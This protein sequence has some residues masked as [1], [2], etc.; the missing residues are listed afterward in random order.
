MGFSEDYFKQQLKYEKL[1]GP[2][3]IVLMQKGDFFEMF[4]Y[5][6]DIVDDNDK[7]LLPECFEQKLM[8]KVSSVCDSCT[9]LSVHL[10][11]NKLDHSFKNLIT[12]GFRL[13]S[14]E[15]YKDI[16][17]K[18][19]WVP[20]QII[21]S[22]SNKQIRILGEEPVTPG[23]YIK[24]DSSEKL[25]NNYI[26]NVYIEIIS[27]K[28]R[29]SNYN[30]NC[31]ISCLDVNTG[32][33]EISEI[34]N[35]NDDSNYAIK[36]IY[37][38]LISKRPQEV[39]IYVKGLKKVDVIEGYENYLN[40]S[41]KLENYPIK[42][43]KYDSDILKE[44]FEIS[45]Q[46]SSLKKIFNKKFETEN[47]HPKI[48]LI[49]N[50]IINDL[51]LHKIN[52]GRI[53]YIML[54]DHV[55]KQ[56]PKILYKIK[57][58][59]IGWLDN[60]NLILTHNAV[61]Q[62]NLFPEDRMFHR[63]NPIRSV[64]KATSLFEIINQTSTKMGERR[65]QKLLYNPINDIEKLNNSY[66][67]VEEMIQDNFWKTMEE[68]LKSIPDIERLQRMLLLKNIKPKELSRLFLSYNCITKIYI[69]IYQ[70]NKEN[71]KKMLINPKFAQNYNQAVNII[72]KRF[73]LIKLKSCNIVKDKHDN[74]I[75]IKYEDFPLKDENCDKFKKM[76]KI[77][78]KLYYIAEEIEKKSKGRGKTIEFD[79][80]LK[81]KRADKGGLINTSTGF[82]TSA[83]KAKSL[84]KITFGEHIGQLEFIKTK[85]QTFI[86]STKISELAEEFENIRDHLKGVLWNVYSETLE[87][88]SKDYNYYDEITKF[89]AEIDLI[90]SHAKS[91][92]KYKYYKPEL[93]K[94]E[95]SFI[96]ATEL[97]H[98]LVE[99]IRD[100]EYI[101]NDISLGSKECQG[102]LLYGAN[103]VGKTTLTKSVGI[104]VIMAQIGGYT[105]GKVKLCPYNKI[106]TR[107]T[108]NDSLIE[109]KS[110]FVVELSEVL[111]IEKNMDK[112]TLVLGDELCRGTESASG[113][114][115][116]ITI[117]EM[118]IE[119]QS[120]YIFS[121]HM[122]HLVEMEEI[123]NIS[124]EKLR[125]CHLEMI[126]D[127]VT[128]KLIYNRKLKDGPGDAIYGLETAKYLGFG[129]KFMERSM[130]IRNRL[131][132]K[133]QNIISTKKSKY[134][135]DVFVD[136]CLLCGKR[137]NLESHHIKEQ[138]KADL[139]GFINHVHKDSKYNLTILCNDC[140]HKLI[141][142]Q[143]NEIKVDQSLGCS[144][145]RVEKI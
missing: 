105:A 133:S 103:Q 55:Y 34:Y 106:I 100:E 107:L 8:G 14:Y 35:Q 116:T 68:N 13:D 54:L 20:I 82:L 131:L 15:K 32:E 42:I 37:R 142:A 53:S 49:R 97:R 44:Y 74:S 111:T 38:Y 22:P 96:E 51:N 29:Y 130:Q 137:I 139:N 57:T 52:Y 114:S 76:Q 10:E 47:L 144:V 143:N 33:N 70:S 101:S 102:I 2:R 126:Y 112:N 23:A 123:T 136:S 11:K 4:E 77:K 62:S 69:E 27:S 66:K 124:K 30:I 91:A 127:S 25:L 109:G 60:Q 63:Y 81:N 90:K 65:L 145:Y 41:L 85:T 17:L 71:L 78:E 73:D 80:N 110:S 134:N 24:D 56:N 83:S 120:S 9:N 108:G 79:E 117:L 45:Y 140:H 48:K 40:K 119:N 12:A 128:D 18:N 122:H 59:I 88:L 16:L 31:G 115:I 113:T 58:P 21:Q 67:L 50:N 46:E 89:I 26:I 118:L 5:D 132:N 75:Q 43:F 121:T 64:K 86:T 125:I 99:R 72:N 129:K 6:P 28:C 1:Y 7:H 61:I 19:N 84:E 39:L 98:P 92:I 93:V 3:T 135:K 104:A 94:E 138:H 36:E 87:E 95:Y 141:H